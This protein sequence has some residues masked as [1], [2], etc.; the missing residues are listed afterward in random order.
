MPAS[1]LAYAVFAALL[2]GI[3]MPLPV[4]AAPQAL[5][6]I[7][8]DEPVAFACVES[9]CVLHLPTFCLQSYRDPPRYGAPYQVVAGGVTLIVAKRDGGS[10]SLPA[11]NRVH[12]T[13][14]ENFSSVTLRLSPEASAAFDAASIALSIEPGTVL[15]PVAAPGDAN[16]QDPLEIAIAIGPARETALRFL[17]SGTPRVAAA[18]LLSQA[19]TVLPE[20]GERTDFDGR[21]VWNGLLDREAANGADPAVIGLAREMTAICPMAVMRRCLEMRQT[22]LLREMN[23][24]L[25]D[26]LGGS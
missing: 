14:N 15:L 2:A 7:A 19:I 23:D 5:A 17:A 8:P 9:G 3:F 12:I 16:P 20:F 10:F 13:A 26:R 24:R 25:W 6:V 18:Q 21:A 11:E 1:R 4:S 22:D